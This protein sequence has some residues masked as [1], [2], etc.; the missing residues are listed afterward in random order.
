MSG[1]HLTGWISMVVLA[2]LVA[3]CLLTLPYSFGRIAEDGSANTTAR[4]AAGHPSAAR[5][6]PLWVEP[7]DVTRA[8]FEDGAVPRFWLGSDLL[9]RSVLVRCLAGGA[10]SLLVGLV[11]A[12]VSVTVGTLYGAI[13]AY[14]GGLCDTV[15][16]RIVDVL[17]GLPYVLLVVLL[18]VAGES[19]LSEYVSRHGDRVEFVRGAVLAEAPGLSVPSDLTQWLSDHPER[20]AAIE[21]AAM[22]AKPP[23]VL[24]EATRIVFDLATLVIA[25]GGVSWLTMARVIRGQVLSLKARPFMDAARVVGASRLRIF[26]RHLLPNLVGPIVVYATLTVPQAILQ[27]SFLSFLGIGVKP[28]LPSWGNLAAEGLGELHPYRSHW[29]LLVFPC[30]LLTLTLVSLNFV[31]EM[32]RER[33]DPAARGR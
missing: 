3:M 28:P 13:A 6:P 8:R 12:A 7:D 14:A 16:M 19:V 9:G 1:R 25:I 32:V 26:F 29:W 10:I 2:A 4:Y 18:A 33:L 5:V 22:A 31:G 17:Y 11:A 23:R 30:G 20:K 27:E 15:M 21:A 24:G